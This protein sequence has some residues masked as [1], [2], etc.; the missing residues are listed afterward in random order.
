MQFQLPGW[1]KLETHLRAC[2]FDPFRIFY[3]LLTLTPLP[4]DAGIRASI[5]WGIVTLTLC[6]HLH[7]GR[8]ADAGA[9]SGLLRYRRVWRRDGVSGWSLA[10][11]KRRL[12]P[13]GANPHYRGRGLTGVVGTK[14]LALWDDLIKEPRGGGL[15]RILTAPYFLLLVLWLV[16]FTVSLSAFYTVRTAVAG[17]VKITYSP[18]SSVHGLGGN[19]I[20]IM[21]ETE[22]LL[23]AAANSPVDVT[24]TWNFTS[25][26]R[27]DSPFPTQRP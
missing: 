5:V 8:G 19:K 11:P 25:R 6:L 24:I 22:V 9:V 15:P 16:G 23:A 2:P 13:A 20:G 1:W 3:R 14:L 7:T 10:D 17:E 21:P 4:E 12:E 18:Q 26:N 27:V